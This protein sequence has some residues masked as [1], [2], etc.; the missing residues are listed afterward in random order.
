MLEGDL[1]QDCLHLS[2]EPTRAVH[3]VS[4]V[5]QAERL[6]HVSGKGRTD[7]PPDWQVGQ[8]PLLE[9]DRLTHVTD[10]GDRREQDRGGAR[11]LQEAT[12]FHKVCRAPKHE[13]LAEGVRQLQGLHE[14][15]CT[16]QHPS[17]LDGG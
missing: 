3:G 10:S 17:R 8:R 16:K 1:P 14:D 7:L 11:R 9:T 4:G 15:P 5:L 6:G 12:P 13:L 2:L